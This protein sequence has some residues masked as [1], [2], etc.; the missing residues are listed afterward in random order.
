MSVTFPQVAASQVGQT[1][2]ND[3]AHALGHRSA[4]HCSFISV[5]PAASL[6]WEKEAGSAAFRCLGTRGFPLVKTFMDYKERNTVWKTDCFLA[7]C[8]GVT[9]ASGLE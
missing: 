5:L 8:G 3:R 7:V 2:P 9:R 6:S 1:I 4:E